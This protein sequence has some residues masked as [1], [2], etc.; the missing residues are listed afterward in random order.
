MFSSE[1]VFLVSFSK[2]KSIVK[3][4]KLYNVLFFAPNGTNGKV[5]LFV[6]RL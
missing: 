5:N 6:S 3:V 1:L 2:T 4:E